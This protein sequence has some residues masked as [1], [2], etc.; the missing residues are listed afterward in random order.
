LLY[1]AFTDLKKAKLLQNVTIVVS[2]VWTTL[3]NRNG[4]DHGTAA[5][6][7]VIGG[8]NKEILSSKH[9]SRLTTI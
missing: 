5:P 3:N 9:Q 7:F 8:S 4:T 2:G 1:L 6:M